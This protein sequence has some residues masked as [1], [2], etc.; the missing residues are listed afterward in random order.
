MARKKQGIQSWVA[1]AGTAPKNFARLYDT[2]LKHPAIIKLPFSARHLFTC[3]LQASAGKREFHLT[4]SEY[5]QYGFNP[6]TFHKAKEKL[7]EACIIKIARSG[8]T[9]RTPNTYAFRDCG[10]WIVLERVR[11]KKMAIRKT[12]SI[13]TQEN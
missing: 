6:E 9:T 4:E 5:K 11:N 3:M 10:E 2:T 8:W 1:P 13:D 7:I 12:E